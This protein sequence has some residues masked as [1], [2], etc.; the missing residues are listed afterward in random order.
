MKKSYLLITIALLLLLLVINLL[1]GS[2]SSARNYVGGLPWYGWA[3]VCAFLVVVG[4]SFA[5]LDAA[6]ARRLL[7]SVGNKK[8]EVEELNTQITREDLELIKQMEPNAPAYPHPVIFA[9]RCI[10]CHACVEACPHDVLAIVDGIATVVAREQCMED[11][12]CQ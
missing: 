8:F 11:T 1:S 3:A 7:A 4:A 6:R 9:D 12:S 2:D 10:G 5:L